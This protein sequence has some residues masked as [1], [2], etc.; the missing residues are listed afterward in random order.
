MQNKGPIF[1][2]GVKGSPALLWGL[3]R[4]VLSDILQDW[5]ASSVN[6][7]IRSQE[8]QGVVTTITWHQPAGHQAAFYKA[9]LI[10]LAQGPLTLAVNS[11]LSSCG[12]G[13]GRDPE[14]SMKTFA[15]NDVSH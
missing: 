9:H 6:V 5:R 2:K 7:L 8:A 15:G 13:G 12:R 11:R 1:C 4:V 3:Q 10:R 14:T